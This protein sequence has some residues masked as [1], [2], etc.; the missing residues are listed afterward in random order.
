LQI[1]LGEF[2]LMDHDPVF[3]V[4]RPARSHRHATGQQPVAHRVSGNPDESGDLRGGQPQPQV[5]VSHQLI[6][7]PGLVV[8]ATS[9]TAGAAWLTAT[10]AFRSTQLNRCRLLPVI[11]P[12]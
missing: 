9:G 10:P 6:Q 1:Q 4:I 11:R 12:I 8:P 3:P 2:G 7:V 5:Q